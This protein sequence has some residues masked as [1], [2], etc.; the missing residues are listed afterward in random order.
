[1]S[2]VKNSLSMK[3]TYSDIFLNL[4][5]FKLLIKYKVPMNPYIFSHEKSWILI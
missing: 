5:I 2:W 1:M 4:S 3:H